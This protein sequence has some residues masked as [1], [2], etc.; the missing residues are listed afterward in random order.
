LVSE[1]RMLAVALGHPF[2]RRETV[3]L[4]DIARTTPIEPQAT[5]QETLTLAGAGR[6]VAEVGAQTRRYYPRPD[7]VYVP[8]SDAAP[9][10]WCLMWHEDRETARVRAFNQVADELVHPAD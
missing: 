3:S 5:L 8:I 4:A 2:A 1:K 6:G 9:V 7:V 10:E